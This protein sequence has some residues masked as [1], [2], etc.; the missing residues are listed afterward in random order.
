MNEI[1]KSNFAVFITFWLKLLK[2]DRGDVASP[3][4]THNIELVVTSSKSKHYQYSEASFNI[5]D[6]TFDKRVF[7]F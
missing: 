2:G 1:N 4:K 7:F 6:M 3:T 5:S